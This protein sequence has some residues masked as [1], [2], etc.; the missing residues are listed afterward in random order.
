MQTLDN[1]VSIFRGRV[2]AESTKKTYMLYFKSYKEFCSSIDIPLV[3]ISKQ[4]LARY[5]AHLSQRLCFNSIV[6]YLNIVRLLHE[7]A[8]LVV[9]LESHFIQSVLKGVKRSLGDTRTKKLPITPTIIRGI[10]STIDLSSNLDITFWAACLVAF[11]SFFRKSNLFVPSS[12][13]IDPSQHLTRSSVNFT[14]DEVI[15]TVYKTKTIQH[16]EKILEVPL[17][18]IRNSPLCPYQA[19]S[20]SCKLTPA[21]P[22]S[23]AFMYMSGHKRV[24]LTY[25]RF[26]E[27]LKI[28]LTKLGYDSSKYSGHSFRRGGASFALECGIP[29]ELIQIQGDWKSDAYKGYLDPSFKH[30]K[31]IMDTFARHLQ[32]AC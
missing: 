17:P 24:P 13:E 29:P 21:S 23:S 15:L 5:I 8:E 11:F 2:F 4:N 18:K 28:S 22:A 14:S 9:P 25:S 7:E 20:L 26:L 16:R 3:P 12:S 10:F 19:L 1:L 32:T 6:N 27:R 30:R 31:S